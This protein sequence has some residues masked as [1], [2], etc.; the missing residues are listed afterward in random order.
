[1]CGGRGG[2]GPR[3]ERGLGAGPGAL[4]AGKL[5][6]VNLYSLIAQVRAWGGEPLSLGVARDSVPELEAKIREGMTADLLVTSAGVSV[7]DYD[8]VKPVLERLGHIEFWRGNMKPARPIAFGRIGDLPM[9]GLPGNPASL[10][11]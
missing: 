1:G 9:V 5:R 7:G 3:G 6:N 2:G 8:V 4:G 11:V 10:M